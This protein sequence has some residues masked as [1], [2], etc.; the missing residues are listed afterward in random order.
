M[1]AAPAVSAAPAAPAPIWAHS[2]LPALADAGAS[3]RRLGA[4]RLLLGA[5]RLYQLAHQG[6]LPCCRF[7]PTCSAYAV[8]AI[9]VH[10]LA[11]GSCL[12][13]VRLSKCRPWGGHGVDPVPPRGGLSC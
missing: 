11:R 3:H 2:G 6:R 12:A 5:L 1:S 13:I 7:V 9:E 10:G 8:E 4:T